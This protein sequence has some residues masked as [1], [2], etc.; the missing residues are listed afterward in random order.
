MENNAN[1]KDSPIISL[2]GVSKWYEDF[3]ALKNIDLEI[4]LKEKIVICGPSGS[5]KSTLIRCLNRLE[6]HQEGL[7]KVSGIELHE[8]MHDVDVVRQDIGMV[9]QNFNLFPHLT[10]LE[11]AWQDQTGFVELIKM[12]LAIELSRC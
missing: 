7:I 6:A 8:R 5:G 12:R 4:K 3:Q 1:T 11:T 2:K 9:F 10:V